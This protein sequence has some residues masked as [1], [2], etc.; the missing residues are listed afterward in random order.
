[1]IGNGKLK[2]EYE[3]LE[4]EYSA[5]VAKNLDLQY[6]YEQLQA[7]YQNNF[8]QQ[9]EIERLCENTRRLKHDM[10]NHIMVI[11]SYLNSREID[12]AKDYL[13]V[14][15][16]KLNHVYSY[17]Q[18]GNSVMNY[19]INTKLEYAQQHNI[20]FKAEIENL[21]FEKMGSVDFSA[22]L[23]NMLD[24]AIEASIHSVQ[25]FIYIS[26]C[27]KRGYD[28]INIKNKIDSSVINV[29]PELV[30]AKSDADAHGY[31]LKQIKSITEKYDG[32]VDIY[33]DEGMF[34]I[35]V[36]IPSE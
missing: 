2:A 12:K 23:S 32:L 19:I 25:K 31:G 11:A 3:R 26:V 10:K 15:L 1:M 34:C 29:N 14:V 5:E 4:K 20:P 13:S 17:I 6:Q 33:E 27:R 9:K 7:V 36:M 30:S 24:N 28:S 18:T 22:V 35:S 21:P 8:D 16:D